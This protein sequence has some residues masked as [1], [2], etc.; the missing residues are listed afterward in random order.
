VLKLSCWN[1]AKQLHS[2]IDEKGGTMTTIVVKT[3]TKVPVSGQY[4]ASGKNT[5]ATLVRN[6]PAPP[7][8][9]HL[10]NWTLVDRTRHKR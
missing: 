6:E 3:G 2:F 1:D 8:P 10:P 9:G 4:K 5:E 7:N